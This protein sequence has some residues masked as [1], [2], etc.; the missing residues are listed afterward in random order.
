MKGKRKENGNEKKKG[1]RR[2]NGMKKNMEKKVKEIKKRK[3]W[4]LQ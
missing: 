1:E 2:G 3:I 4:K